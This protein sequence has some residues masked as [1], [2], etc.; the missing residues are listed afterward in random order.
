MSRAPII[1]GS[2]KLA[3]PTHTG[4]IHRNTMIEPCMVNS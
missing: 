1:S 4:M 2:M 3:K